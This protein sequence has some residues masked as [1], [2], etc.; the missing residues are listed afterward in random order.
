VELAVAG[1]ETALSAKTGYLYTAARK[2]NAKH[3][4]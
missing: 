2:G 4:G 1:R 3:R